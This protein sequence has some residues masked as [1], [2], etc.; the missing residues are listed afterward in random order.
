MLPFKK[1]LYPT[2]FSDPSYE[3][4]KVANELALHFSAE[5]CVVHVV[6]PVAHAPADPSGSG[7]LVL[8][9]ME[10]AARESLKEMVKERIPKE[11]LVRQIVVLGGASE[12]IIQ[13]SEKERVDL[14]VIATHGQTGWRHFVFGSVAEKVVRLAP[15]PVL[16]IRAPHKEGH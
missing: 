14:I 13:I 9:E 11:L 3:A 15:C 6:S 8:Q 2:D 16:T 12:E 7:F 5:L 4:L 1:I 10:K